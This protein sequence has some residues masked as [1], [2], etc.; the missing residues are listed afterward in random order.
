[1]NCHWHYS[2]RMGAMLPTGTRFT[3]PAVTYGKVMGVSWTG[4][5]RVSWFRGGF[6]DGFV[7]RRN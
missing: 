6:V 7:D 5:V 4:F 3:N 2:I 1:M